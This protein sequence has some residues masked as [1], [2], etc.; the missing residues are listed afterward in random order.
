[1]RALK[2]EALIFQLSHL[3]YD[4]YFIVRKALALI[5]QLFLNLFF[6]MIQIYDFVVVEIITFELNI[7][8]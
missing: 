4:K 6:I 2:S 5:M 3:I 1:M 7:A 8:L